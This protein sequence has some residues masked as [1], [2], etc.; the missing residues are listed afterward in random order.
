MRVSSIIASAPTG[1]L[2]PSAGLGPSVGPRTLD[3][4]R[5]QAAHRGSLVK[6]REHLEPDQLHPAGELSLVGRR[7]LD[8]RSDRSSK[9]GT[10]PRDVSRRPS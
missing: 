6:G 9:L 5:G 2:S 4:P 7:S 1:C 10:L 8:S 3:F